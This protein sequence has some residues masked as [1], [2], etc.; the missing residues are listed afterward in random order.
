M[1]LSNGWA[2]LFGLVL[3]NNK[4]QENVHVV[5]LQHQLL[6]KCSS[7]FKD[8]LHFSRFSSLT[9]VIIFVILTGLRIVHSETNEC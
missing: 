1:M 8:Y 7:F 4:S 9:V 5:L 3:F 2:L 6:L